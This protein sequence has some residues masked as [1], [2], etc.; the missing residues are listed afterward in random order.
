VTSQKE[1]DGGLM[2]YISKSCD[3]FDDRIA[4]KGKFDGLNG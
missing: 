1:K 2:A 4:K 3:L